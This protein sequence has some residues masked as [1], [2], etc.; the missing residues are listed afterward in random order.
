MK[1]DPSSA[2]EQRHADTPSARSAR[3]S[4]S[5]RW[6]W[7]GVPV[8]VLAA[9]GSG[10][11]LQQQQRVEA[12][13]HALTRLAAEEKARDQAQAHAYVRE[14]E[15][16]GSLCVGGD[17]ESAWRT[18]D[19]LWLRAPSAAG[20]VAAQTAQADCGMS[21]L[22]ELEI[23]GYEKF[24][25]IALR[26]MPVL[27]REAAV[28]QGA[29]LGDLHAHLGWAH[30][31]RA[32]EGRATAAAL[33]HYQRA[34]DADPRNPYANAMWAQ[35]GDSD[36]VVAE[37]F[38]TALAS[39]REM[40]F[41]RWM[42]VGVANNDR[43]RLARVLQSFNEG[44]KRGEPRPHGAELLFTLLCEHELLRLDHR[45]V[46]LDALP[47]DDAIAT[48]EWVQPHETVR[49]EREPLWHLCGSAY[50][51]HAHRYAEADAIITR[52]LKTMGSVFRGGRWEQWAMEQLARFKPAK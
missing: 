14:V 4:R 30:F 36:D 15:A 13:R 51:V 26:V 40:V 43:A 29:R 47:A 22:R 42:Q 34:V 38:E 5:R 8:L 2:A 37:R 35:R 7:I 3:S 9:A 48:I 20:K 19:D 12:R 32:P 44:R 31:L 49:D 21:W 52:T 50:L 25:D 28:S 17:R 11:Y 39:G 41:V 10:W 46:L 6:W 23:S 45:M 1:R 27:G 16:A 33:S 24:A 18:F